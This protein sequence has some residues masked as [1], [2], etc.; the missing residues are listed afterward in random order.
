MVELCLKLV[1]AG[2][3]DAVEAINAVGRLRESSDHLALACVAA[4]ELVKNGV[5]KD[6][7][8]GL[9][10]ECVDWQKRTLSLTVSLKP[11]CLKKNSFEALRALD[12]VRNPDGRSGWILSVIPKKI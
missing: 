7:L 3:V 5:P 10:W 12:A 2:H 1:G 11:I 4:R 8:D 6:R 9:R